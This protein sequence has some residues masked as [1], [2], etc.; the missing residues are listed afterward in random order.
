MRPVKI[1]IRLREC[2]GWSESLLGASDVA[3]QMCFDHRLSVVIRQCITFR[4][5]SQQILK[6]EISPC[7]YSY[8]LSSWTRIYTALANSVDP[9]Q[10]ASSLYSSFKFCVRVCFRMCVHYSQTQ[11]FF[12]TLSNTVV[13]HYSQTQSFLLESVIVWYFEQC[14]GR[15]ISTCDVHLKFICTICFRPI[16][17]THSLQD[18]SFSLM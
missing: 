14:F 12:I 16:V 10:L 17:Q 5:S 3:A 7:I 9:D 15:S 6:R 11:S 13:L 4:S 1:L 18:L 8:P 2:A